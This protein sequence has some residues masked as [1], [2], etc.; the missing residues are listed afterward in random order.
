MSIKV[1]VKKLREDAILPKRHSAGAAGFDLYAS[2]LVVLRPWA[3]KDVGTGIAIEIPPGY[4]GQIR[5]RSGLS[6]QKVVIPNAPGTIDSDYRGE[7]KVLM[8]EIDGDTPPYIVSKGDRI[9]QLVITPV[10]DVEFEVV[11]ELSDTERGEGGFG[12]TGRGLEG[13]G[14]DG[15]YESLRARLQTI[16]DEA[17]GPQPEMSADQLL[18]VVERELTRVGQLEAA[19]VDIKNSMALIGEKKK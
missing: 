3:V 11:D 9:A 18:S 7:I 19:V 6:M 1:K 4:E 15:R 10:Q 14:E 5:P 12:S 16:V 17:L 8:M 13:K 2:S